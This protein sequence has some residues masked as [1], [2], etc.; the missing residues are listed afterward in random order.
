MYAYTSHKDAV[1]VHVGPKYNRGHQLDGIVN[2]VIS[3]TEELHRHTSK[4]TTIVES[5]KTDNWRAWAGMPKAET[6]SK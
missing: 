6:V 3:Q 1:Y 4:A 2:K 5:T